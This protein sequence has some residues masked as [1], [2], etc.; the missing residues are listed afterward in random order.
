MLRPIMLGE[1]IF[2]SRNCTTPQ[3]TNILTTITQLVDAATNIAGVIAITG[4]K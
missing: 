2:P 1:I 4:P 3:T